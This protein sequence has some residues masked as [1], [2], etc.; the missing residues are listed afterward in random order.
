[1]GLQQ[2][3][4]RADAERI[5]SLVCALVGKRG[6]VD[7]R[8][9][10]VIRDGAIGRNSGTAKRSL[11]HSALVGYLLDSLPNVEL[12][13]QRAS[14]R[15]R[16]VEGGVVHSCLRPRHDRIPVARHPGLRGQVVE[17]Y[18]A[19]VD[20]AAQQLVVL[21]RV[22]G[23]V[24]ERHRRELRL[25]RSRVVLVRGQDDLAVWSVALQVERAVDDLPQR[26]RVVGG[27]LACLAVEVR[28][29][30][31][32]ASRGLVVVTD[33]AGGRGL[34]PGVLRHREEQAE[35]VVEQP[36]AAVRLL[37]GDAERRGRGVRHAGDVVRQVA[38]DVVRVA[39]LVRLEHV[40]PELDVPG[41]DGLTVGPLPV[42]HLDGDGLV[43]V[44]E[45]RRIGQAQR[46]VERQ[47]ATGVAEPVQRAPHLLDEPEDLL[48][49]VVGGREHRENV[50]RLGAGQVGNR[51]VAPA[52]RGP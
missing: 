45:H 15:I 16:V 43:A 34:V 27:Q 8:L 46:L 1:M 5:G 40:D 10:R 12:R 26:I 7:L 6:A 30:R 13:E 2:A 17:R 25:V 47:A 29:D 18:V 23:E 14:R 44:R 31:L 41:R 4:G 32:G 51:H 20:V 33:L 9:R 35:L 39:R 52:L 22:A 11:D 48:R 36:V 3:H 49:G 42:L 38:G 21:G 28:E 19:V 24:E 37:E 50:Y